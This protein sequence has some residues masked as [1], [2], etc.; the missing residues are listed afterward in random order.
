MCDRAS[1]RETFAYPVSDGVL[2]APHLLDFL[3]AMT[4]EP[5]KPD[6]HVRL[7]DPPKLKESGPARAVHW[8]ARHMTVAR[9]GILAGVILG[10]VCHCL[11][12]EYRHACEALRSCIPG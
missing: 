7:P 5:A 4:D 3:T 8:V 10:L 2:V 11:P 6:E 9:W 12:H 1:S